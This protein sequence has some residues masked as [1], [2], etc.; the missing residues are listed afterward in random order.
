[1]A[2]ASNKTICIICEKI[3]V[4]YICQGCSN[5]FCFPHLSEH[6]T[7]IAREFDEL[8]NDHDQL[9]QQIIDWKNDFTKHPLIKQIDQWEED[10][11]KKIQQQAKQCKKEWINYS[12]TFLLKMEKKLHD[13]AERIKEIHREDAFNEIDVN[14]LKRT[15]ENLE[16]QLNQPANVFIHKKSTSFINK[17]SLVLPSGKNQSRCF[18][19]L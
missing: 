4:T 11:I 9:R 12:N 3:K 18:S 6:R 10:S 15:S 17:I 13:L 19:Y 14:H 1:M 8:Q 7:N 5:H 2:T 16:K